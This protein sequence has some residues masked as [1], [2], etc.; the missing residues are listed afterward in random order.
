MTHPT[1]GPMNL[2][3]SAIRMSETPPAIRLPPPMLG[4]NSEEILAA[5]GYEAAAVAALKKGGVI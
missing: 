3:S 5:L 2:L 1:M 4:E